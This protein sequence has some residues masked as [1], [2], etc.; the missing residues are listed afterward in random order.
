MRRLEVVPEQ[1]PCSSSNTV[2]CDIY[3]S[4]MEAYLA[5]HV[6]RT[7]V[8]RAMSCLVAMHCLLKPLLLVVHPER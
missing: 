2:D 4:S 3:L 6:G 5:S 1:S 7:E 8:F